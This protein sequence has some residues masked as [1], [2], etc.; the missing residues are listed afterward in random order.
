M[1]RLIIAAFLAVMLAR[2]ASAA[3]LPLKDMLHHLLAERHLAY[4]STA[5]TEDHIA[6]SF[7]V[8]KRTHEWTVI[9]VDN[10][11]NACEV[12]RGYDWFFA[13]ERGA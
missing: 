9:L 11:N 2:P 4:M 1:K 8:N 5:I 10:E 3:C 6:L 12:L 7:F 13:M